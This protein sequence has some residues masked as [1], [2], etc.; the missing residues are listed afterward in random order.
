ML[1]SVGITKENRGMKD[2]NPLYLVES[3]TAASGQRLC[4]HLMEEQ[5]H[6][7]CDTTLL[8]TI[9]LCLHLKNYLSGRQIYSLITNKPWSNIQVVQMNSKALKSQIQGYPEVAPSH[10]LWWVVSTFKV[11]CSCKAESQWLW[12]GMFKVVCLCA[13]IADFSN[14]ISKSILWLLVNVCLSV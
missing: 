10:G 14:F 4:S 12:G 6:S 2:T 9:G 8:C 7:V 13:G 1:A 5:P 3:I 11:E